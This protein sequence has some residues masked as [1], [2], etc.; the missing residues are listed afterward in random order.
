MD[1]SVFLQK[2]KN[3]IL[4]VA[5]LVLA[6]IISIKIYQNQDAQIAALKIQKQ[7]EA[8][9]NIVFKNLT[10]LDNKINTYKRS[11]KI[12]NSGEVMNT[13]GEIAKSSGLKIDSIRPLG[14]IAGDDYVRIPVS[15][16]MKAKNFNQVGK[17]MSKLESHPAFFTVDSFRV[18]PNSDGKGLA[19]NFAVS[20]I[21]VAD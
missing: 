18:G 8:E 3:A 15:V 21:R 1:A 7:S 17:F 5:I 16:A 6:L 4:N 11:F 13:I 2:N 14:D 20:A 12:R 9:N 19:L 10:Q